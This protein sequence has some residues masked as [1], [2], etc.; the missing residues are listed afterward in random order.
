MVDGRYMVVSGAAN[1]LFPDGS[2]FPIVNKASDSTVVIPHPAATTTCPL[3]PLVLATAVHP[4][5]GGAGPQPVCGTGQGC[6]D[7]GMISDNATITLNFTQG[8]GMHIPTF[9][10]TVNPGNDFVMTAA[11]T[12]AF[13]GI[14]QTGAEF[15]VAC[16]ATVPGSGCSAGSGD[17][18][19][20]NIVTTDGS[21]AGLSPLSMPAP[22]TKRVQ[23]RCSGLAAT[24]ITVPAEAAAYLMQANSGATR[25]QATFIRGDL[26]GSTGTTHSVNVVSGHAITTFKTVTECNDGRDNG[27]ADSDVDFPADTGCTSA[28]DTS[29]D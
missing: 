6:P 15:T 1:A 3:A 4:T 12:A 25:I 7:P 18:V 10:N 21:I 14:P 8:G 26:D 5:F 16:D 22:T 17:G 23:V 24:S 27:D 29:E 2:S 28:S 9:T 13:A 11:T 20:L 19:V